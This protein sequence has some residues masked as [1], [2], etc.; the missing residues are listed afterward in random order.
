MA[1]V[2]NDI[3]DVRKLGTI[4]GVWAHPDDET[5]CMG[6]LMAAAR[7]NSQEI[8]LVTATRGEAGI[9]DE[10]RWPARKLGDIRQTE[11]MQALDILDVTNHHW[12]DYP[13]GGLH[14]IDQDSAIQRLVSLI[15]TYK[16]DTIIT[17]GPDGMT[18]HSDHCVVSRWVSRAH[19]KSDTQ[20][21][22][23]YCTQT[24]KQ[25]RALEEPHAHLDIFFNID[26]PCTCSEDA[27]AICLELPDEI[28]AIKLEALRAMPSQTEQL[29]SQFPHEVK[30]AFKVEAFT[31][32]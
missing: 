11:L 5:F 27:C 15:D 10:S 12:L 14:R 22:L 28:Y 32:A 21:E 31:R 18:G 7:K 20:A 13:D 8:V 1:H 3:D 16:P 9:Q 19:G 24:E 4:L 26:T 2:V 17:F 6:G 25:V 29:L 30:E 23:Y